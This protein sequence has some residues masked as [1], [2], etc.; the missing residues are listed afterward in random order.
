MAVAGPFFYMLISKIS[1][2]NYMLN[3]TVV[4]PPINEDQ[5]VELV[6][7]IF[8]DKMFFNKFLGLL[9]NDM[10]IWIV[11][12]VLDA[13]VLGSTYIEFHQAFYEKSGRMEKEPPKI[14]ARLH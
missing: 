2:T 3:N 6:I 5:K 10:W 8:S 12:S 1:S 9:M 13:F 7:R 14:L 4:L 11:N